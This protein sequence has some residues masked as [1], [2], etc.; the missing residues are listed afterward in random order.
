MRIAQLAL[1]AV[2]STACSVTIRLGNM[3][4]ENDIPAPKAHPAPV[5]A[6]SPVSAPAK[7]I[8]KAASKKARKPVKSTA[9]VC[10]A[11]HKEADSCDAEVKVE[12]CKAACEPTPA[13]PAAP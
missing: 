6:S 1:I 4:N 9:D 10:A 7:P 3:A 12:T 2:L 13:A 8:V 5:V 11:K